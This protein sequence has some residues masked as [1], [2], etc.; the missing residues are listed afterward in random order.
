MCVGISSSHPFN[1]RFTSGEDDSQRVLTSKGPTDGVWMIKVVVLLPFKMGTPQGEHHI[2]DMLERG[3]LNVMDVSIIA[4]VTV[5]GTFVISYEDTRIPLPSQEDQC[6][7][8]RLEPR[9][10]HRFQCLKSL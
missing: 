8:Q 9:L 6:I 1:T 10:N 2:Y 3:H 5:A 7:G 4:I